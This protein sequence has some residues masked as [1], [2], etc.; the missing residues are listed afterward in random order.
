LTVRTDSDLSMRWNAGAFNNGLIFGL[1]Y[2]GVRWLPEVC[3]YAL[4]D[5]GT[6]MAYK[7][8]QHGTDALVSNLRV[9]SPERSEEE[10]RRLALLTY[11]SYARDTVDFIR[12]L[13]MPAATVQRKVA[14]LEGDRFDELLAAKRGVI[15]VGGHFGN[16][17][18]GG[19]ALRLLR[20]YSLTVV[21]K[22]EA[23]PIVNMLRRR[24]RDSLGIDSL[25]IGQVLDTALRIRGLLAN[26]RIV[27]MLA[28]RH[29][30]RDR[31]DVTFFGRRA[32][33]LRS[34][35]M[36]GLMS[37]APLLP[38]FMMRQADG[39]F[40][41]LCGEPIVVDPSIDR[42]VAVTRAMQS[43]ASQLEAQIRQRPHLWYQFYPYWADGQHRDG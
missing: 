7:L 14:Q 9:I 5:A 33:F 11:R 35:A 37:G 41:G 18:L 31:V 30:G 42:D 3:S 15:L 19:V 24:M 29:I 8:V 38:S 12:S 13:S 26:N 21:G 34:P 40:V 39:R 27:A 32:S 6:W 16:W 10:L 25:E 17:E 23:S 43:F 4:G 1:T 20:N 2:H 36:I 22:A 28:D